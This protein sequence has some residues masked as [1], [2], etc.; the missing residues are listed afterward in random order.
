MS[1]QILSTFARF[2]RA[3]QGNVTIVFSIALPIIIGAI[4]LSV[5]ISNLYMRRTELQDSADSA[6]LAAAKELYMA[7]ADRA[8]IAT[9]AE[10]YARTNIGDGRNVSIKTTL[11]DKDTAVTVEIVEETKL[12]FASFVSSDLS[13]IRVSSTARAAGG[14]RICIVGMESSERRAVFLDNS[15]K[16]H[17]PT[18]A[19]YS[20]S[21]SGAGIVAQK[22]AYL[23]SELTCSAGG[24]KGGLS[25]FA[26]D[27]VLDC[28]QIPDPLAS[29]NPPA[30]SGCDYNNYEI[31]SDDVTIYP[32]VYCGGLVIGASARVNAKSGIYVIKDG[33]MAVTGKAVLQGKYVSFFLADDLASLKFAPQTTIDIGAPKSGDMAGI[34]IYENRDITAADKKHLIRSNNARNLLGTIYLPKSRLVI[35]SNNKI[36]DRSAYT[37]IIARKIE[38]RAEPELY[39]NTNYS[40]TDVP[41]PEGITPVGKNVYLER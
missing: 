3:G 40:S 30:Y 26:H 25:N 12:Y 6:A 37:A 7:G 31:T 13:P 38:L 34:L 4:A 19:V 36:A 39:L 32:G 10:N 24:V 22:S 14:G 21:L 33:P 35:D 27:P 16:I 18:C 9:V 41:V 8:V 15:A 11:V 23:N 1:M 28:P 5:D 2:W 20:N 17:A 29:R